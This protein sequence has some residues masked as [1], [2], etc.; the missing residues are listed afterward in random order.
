MKSK[1]DDAEPSTDERVRG[2]CDKQAKL[3]ELASHEAEGELRT[4]RLLGTKNKKEDSQFL[5]DQRGP[6]NG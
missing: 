3:F 4:T 6:R 5:E 2:L 1:K